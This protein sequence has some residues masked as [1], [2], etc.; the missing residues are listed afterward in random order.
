V[1]NEYCTKQRELSVIKPECVASNNPFSTTASES[2][3]LSFEPYDLPSDD[4]EY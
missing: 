4:D 3:Q 1:E 2:G